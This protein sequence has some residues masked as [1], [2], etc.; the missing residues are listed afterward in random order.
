MNVAYRLFQKSFH[1]MIVA[2][3][4]LSFCHGTAIG[5][6]ALQARSTAPHLLVLMATKNRG[7]LPR[8]LIQRC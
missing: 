1:A 5:Q 8:L 7:Y 4:L 6:S 2:I 3:T